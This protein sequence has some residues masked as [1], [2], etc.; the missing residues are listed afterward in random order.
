MSPAAIDDERLARLD[1][2]YSFP[3]QIARQPD[4]LERVEILPRRDVPH[5]ECGGR[6]TDRCR[7]GPDVGEHLIAEPVL[8]ELRRDRCRRGAS[9]SLEYRRQF[10]G[11]LVIHAL[12]LLMQR[13]RPFCPPV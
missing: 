8:E 6:K 4:R 7:H 13:T 5:R 9:E 1:A 11:L 12:G 2:L 10:S 3:L